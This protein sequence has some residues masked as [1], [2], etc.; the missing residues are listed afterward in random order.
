MFGTVWAAAGAG[1]LGG[2]T[3]VVS[4]VV[5]LALAAALCVGSVRL[6][7]RAGNLP[8][9]DSP[10]GLARRRR[11]VR[12]F[13]LISGVQF[14]AIALAVVLLVRYGLGTSVPAV[15]ALIVGVHFFPLAELYG[16]RAYHVTGAALCALALVAFL[17]T[18]SARLPLVG[19][20]S[21]VALFASATYVLSL[22]GRASR[23]G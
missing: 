23:S 7:R 11:L 22:G 14:V 4:F 13:N 9:D 19:L 18:P 20:G 1:A 21:A 17:L 2:V 8:R 5:C 12:W 10:R 6:R 16:L 15:V 3:G